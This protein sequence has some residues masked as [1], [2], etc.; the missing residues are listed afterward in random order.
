MSLHLSKKKMQTSIQKI[1]IQITNYHMLEI[2]KCVMLKLN[3]EVRKVE[4]L[5]IFENKDKNTKE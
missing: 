3:I 2:C 1:F 4:V 5:G